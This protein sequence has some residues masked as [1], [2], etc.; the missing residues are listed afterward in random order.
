MKQVT[1]GKKKVYPLTI[2]SGII[3][4]EAST[5]EKYARDIPELGIITTKTIG[6]EPRP[7]NIEPILH[8]YEPG[9]FVNAVG[10]KNPG[11][12]AF[13]KKLENIN[14][15]EDK[16]LLIS[17]MGASTEDFCQVITTL[18]K[19]AD[20]FELN[21]SCP[22][23]KGYGQQIGEDP[24]LVYEIVKAVTSI[25]KKQV[26]AKLSPNV[27]DIAQIAEAAMN[28]GAYGITAINTVGPDE[29]K[30]SDGHPILSNKKGGRSGKATLPFGLEAVKKITDKLGNIPILGMGGIRSAEDIR[31]YQNSGAKLF[32]IGSSLAGLDDHQ[33]I[34][35]FRTLAQDLENNSNHAKNQL[36]TV[37]MSYTQTKVTNKIDCAPDFKIIEFD[38]HL[39][40]LPAEFIF[41]WLPGTAEKPFSILNDAP[42]TLAIQERG[43]CTKSINALKAGDNVYIRGPHGKS[44]T[45]LS[46]KHLVLVGGGSGIAGLYI[47]AKHFATTHKITTLLGAKDKDHIFYQDEFRKFGDVHIATEDGSIGTKGYVTELLNELNLD[48]DV[49]FLNCG[50]K[51]MIEALIAIQSQITSNE[52]ILSSIDYLTMCGV[53]ICGSCANANGTRSCVSG[54][55]LSVAS[56]LP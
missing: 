20:G 53:G 49:C 55:F 2:P 33:I 31:A 1:I 41:V 42:L 23:A 21:L 11:C 32:G 26:F 46:H 36:T 54:P 34:K 37:D 18:E 45:E 17:V 19:Y 52:N 10:L 4:T 27:K 13:A 47:F 16:Y 14:F 30:N 44:I 48:T 12:K 5:I 15:P 38:L 43:G 28:A 35:Y 56:R 24:K 29:V 51:P 6:P 22:H 3:T 25:T 39:K 8:Q 7:G 50:P 9:S 40:A